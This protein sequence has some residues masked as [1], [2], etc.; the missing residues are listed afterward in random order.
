MIDVNWACYPSPRTACEVEDHDHI[1]SRFPIYTHWL[2]INAAWKNHQRQGSVSLCV[3]GWHV[4]WR[5]KSRDLGRHMSPVVHILFSSVTLPSTFGWRSLGWIRVANLKTK[6]DGYGTFI[7]KT[8]EGKHVVYD[9][10]FQIWRK[11][12]KTLIVSMFGT[13][14]LHICLVEG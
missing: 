7:I 12:R 14:K 9:R 2:N 10:I 6:I 8:Q 5:Q 3:N 4:S 11:Y 13:K 1:K